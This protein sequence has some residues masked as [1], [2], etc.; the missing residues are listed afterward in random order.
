MTRVIVLD[1]ARGQ[2]R[3]VTSTGG[4]THLDTE[5]VR[6]FVKEQIAYLRDHEIAAADIPDDQALSG[7][8]ETAPEGA[9][10]LD[11]LDQVELALAIE[12]EYNI[13]TPEDLDFE[14]FH[15]VND[16]VDFVVS[17]VQEKSAG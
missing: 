9:L 3:L 7:D 6:A 13:G 10:T 4:P 14:R 5:A 15:T 16:I 17:L 11:S 8:P 12:N 1:N 2:L